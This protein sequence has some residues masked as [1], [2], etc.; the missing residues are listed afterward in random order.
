[1]MYQDYKGDDFLKI[2]ASQLD[3]FKRLSEFYGKF[4]TLPLEEEKAIIVFSDSIWVLIIFMKS[5][6]NWN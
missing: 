2:E 1:M 6:I 5:V 4:S 3:N